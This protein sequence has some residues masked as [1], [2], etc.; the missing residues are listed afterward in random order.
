MKYKILSDEKQMM[1]ESFEIRMNKTIR[2]FVISHKKLGDE[3]TKFK[4]VV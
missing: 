4:K 3:Y 2:D 1:Q